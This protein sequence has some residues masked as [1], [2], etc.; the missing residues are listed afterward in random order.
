MPPRSPRHTATPTH[1]DPLTSIREGRTSHSHSSPSTSPPVCKIHNHRS[2]R[3]RPARVNG[4]TKGFA[5][6]FSRQ[7]PFNLLWKHLPTKAGTAAQLEPGFNVEELVPKRL[8]AA[9]RAL[10]LLSDGQEFP[11]EGREVREAAE[12]QGTTGSTPQL[13]HPCTRQDSWGSRSKHAS[14]VQSSTPRPGCLRSRAVSPRKRGDG[15][16]RSRWRVESHCPYLPA[17]PTRKVQGQHQEKAEGAWRLP[18]YALIPQPCL[19]PTEGKQRR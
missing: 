12:S 18:E 11:A 16:H 10:T 19:M 13:P 1:R 14:T 5:G 6:L 3:A 9:V 2:T 17:A 15:W 8:K 4:V 7:A